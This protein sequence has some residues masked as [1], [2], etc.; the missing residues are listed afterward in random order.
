MGAG[1]AF[2]GDRKLCNLLVTAYN[3]GC[4]FDS[5]SEH[6]KFDMWVKSFEE[7]GLTMDFYNHREREEKE[8]LP[9]DFIDIGVT[10][11]FLKR[12]WKNALEEKVTP[13]CRAKCAGCGVA[14]FGGGVCFESKN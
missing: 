11:E 10:K 6:F 8:L 9:W 7:C 5:W 4:I 12:E 2:R 14:T 3:N 1:R 13:N